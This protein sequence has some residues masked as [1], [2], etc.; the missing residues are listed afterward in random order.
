MRSFPL[1][2]AAPPVQSARQPHVSIWPRCRRKNAL[3]KQAKISFPQ[4]TPW[5]LYFIFGTLRLRVLISQL[6][7]NS[8]VFS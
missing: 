7:Y 2:N 5:A 8:S 6:H 4:K 1:G 3:D